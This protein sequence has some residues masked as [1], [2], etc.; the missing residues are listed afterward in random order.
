MEIADATPPGGLVSSAGERQRDGELVRLVG[1]A[2]ETPHE[3][4]R[5]ALV[6]ALEAALGD[7]DGLDGPPRQLGARAPL[8]PGVDAGP[9]VH[10]RHPEAP[11]LAARAAE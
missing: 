9:F 3:Q 1:A 5:D 8:E 2:R 4:E 10:E 7:R 11:R 6:D